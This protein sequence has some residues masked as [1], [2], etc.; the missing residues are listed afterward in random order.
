MKTWRR[1][2]PGQLLASREQIVRGS[3][4]YPVGTRWLVHSVNSLG[5]LLRIEDTTVYMVWS[6]EDWPR[7]FD[8]ARKPKRKDTT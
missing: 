8:R 2:K 4:L 3:H 7:Y 6:L 1:L 5:A